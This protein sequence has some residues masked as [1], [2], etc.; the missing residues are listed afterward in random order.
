MTARRIALT[1]IACPCRKRR[2]QANKTE[3]DRY[4]F[5][6]FLPVGFPVEILAFLQ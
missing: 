2:L 4:R 1:K 3:P 5:L 6:F